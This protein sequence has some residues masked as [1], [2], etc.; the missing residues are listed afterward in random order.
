M[1]LS[2]VVPSL[3]PLLTEPSSAAVV[4]CLAALVVVAM[5]LSRIPRP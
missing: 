4:V 2:E 5:A 1:K 3:L